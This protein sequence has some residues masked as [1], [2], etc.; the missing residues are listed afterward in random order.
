MHLSLIQCSSAKKAFRALFDVMS[1]FTDTLFNMPLLK[2]L[3]NEY[4]DPLRITLT[5]VS[6]EMT[7]I[8]EPFKINVGFKSSETRLKLI[9]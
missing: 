5:L 3:F 2:M 1:C 6:F 7:V 9:L 8:T 4:E